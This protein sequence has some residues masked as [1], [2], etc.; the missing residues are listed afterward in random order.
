[1]AKRRNTRI[2]HAEIVRLFGQRLRELR[3]SRGM[4]QAELARRS[5]VNVVYIGRLEAGR[6][7]P[8]IDLVEKLAGALG[9]NMSDLLSAAVAPDP[10]AVLKDQAKSLFKGLFESED[11]EVLQTLCL[12]LRLL[13]DRKN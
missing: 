10:L 7:A 6:A 13:A 12:L 3:H 1:M 4:T 9:A 2:A 5:Q 11:K 8:G